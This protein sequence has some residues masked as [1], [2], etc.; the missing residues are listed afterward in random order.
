MPERGCPMKLCCYSKVLPV[1]LLLVL[2]L[3]SSAMLAP[4]LAGGDGLTSSDTD[5]D[6][7]V[8][9]D[10][11]DDPAL[12]GDAEP[13]KAA[14][15][16]VGKVAQLTGELLIERGDKEI[17]AEEGTKVHFGDTLISGEE[18]KAKVE[19]D[20]KSVVWLSE[21]SELVINSYVYDE[22]DKKNSSCVF[23]LAKGS[24]RFVTGTIT[25]INPERFK[26]K[27]RMATIGIRGCEV[28]IEA[29]DRS[30]EIYVFSLGKRETVVVET[31]S[32]GTAMLKAG[33]GKAV[34]IEG[35]KKKRILVNKEGRLILCT[36]G[37]SPEFVVL[38]KEQ[39]EEFRKRTSLVPPAKYK[40]KQDSDG[41]VFE[42]TPV[43]KDADNKEGQSSP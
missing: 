43:D 35:K 30:S 20:D 31:T 22:R 41:S 40:I 15:H 39:I 37:K 18:S 12:E 13:K 24:G 26:V 25:K 1:T 32:D 42:I 29:D 28:G 38:E 10:T 34:D 19:F 6:T 21:L 16:P 23:R 5:E 2:S 36:M 8:Q 4:A 14:T 11:E 33:T 3:V 7:D 17:E 27:T 9:V